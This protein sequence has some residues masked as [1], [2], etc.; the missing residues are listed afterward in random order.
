MGVRCSGP[1]VAWDTQMTKFGEAGLEVGLD[2]TH[3]NAGGAWPEHCMG[4]EAGV[5][6]SVI[7]P[8][9]HSGGA[10]LEICQVSFGFQF[11][12]ALH[13]A[14][15]GMLHTG[16]LDVSWFLTQGQCARL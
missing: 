5:I 16:D 1:S 8:G 14:Y 4:T 9:A 11:R 3:W 13:V 15:Q 2:K 6:G 12:C 7:K 10:V